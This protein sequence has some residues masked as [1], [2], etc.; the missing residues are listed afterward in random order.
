MRSPHPGEPRIM[1][2]AGTGAQ[3]IYTSL[4]LLDSGFRRNDSDHNSQAYCEAIK[5]PLRVT[6]LLDHCPGERM[7]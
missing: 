3:A 7:L 2:G 5:T 1:S 4:G 6:R